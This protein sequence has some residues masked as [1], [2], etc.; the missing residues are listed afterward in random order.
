MKARSQKFKSTDKI[1]K[2]LGRTKTSSSVP[3]FHLLFMRN[4]LFSFW[5]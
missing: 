5:Q 1:K 3:I 2:N 4:Q